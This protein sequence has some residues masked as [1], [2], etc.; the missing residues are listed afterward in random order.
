MVLFT[1]NNVETLFSIEY[2]GI[3]VKLVLI[4]S[5]AYMLIATTT[6]SSR[7]QFPIVLLKVVILA[8]CAMNMVSS[9]SVQ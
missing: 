2:V 1:S 5:L 3:N 6:Q 8:Q 7:H 4:A 9:M